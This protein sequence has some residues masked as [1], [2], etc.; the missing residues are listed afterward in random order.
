MRPGTACGAGL[1]EEVCGGGFGEGEDVGVA[2]DAALDAEDEVV[3][4]GAGGEVLDGVGDHAVEPADAVFAGDADPAGVVER[5]DAG[6]L[7]EGRLVGGPGVV[8][9]GCSWV[10]TDG[11][12]SLRTL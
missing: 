11:G 3:V 4:A 8:G 12:E 10:M 2:L 1:D 9:C 5:G 6:G 7:K